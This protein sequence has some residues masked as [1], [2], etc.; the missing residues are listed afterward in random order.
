MGIR[1]FLRVVFC[2]AILCFGSSAAQAEPSP[3]SIDVL[4]DALRAKG[5]IDQQ[6]AD[7]VLAA[8]DEN[9]LREL[10]AALQEQGV[11]DTESA[12]E[13]LDAD[14]AEREDRSALDRMHLWGDFRNRFKGVWFDEDP[15]GD[16]RNTRTRGQLRLR[17]RGS[18]EVNQYFD[19]QVGVTTVNNNNPG[20]RKNVDWGKPADGAPDD[21]R[22]DQIFATIHP[23][24]DDPLPWGLGQ[25]EVVLGKF[26]P[27]F[28]SDVGKDQ[29]VWDPTLTLDGVALEWVYQPV[30]NVEIATQGSFFQFEVAQEPPNPRMFAMQVVPTWD[31]NDWLALSVS[32][33][34]YAY[35]KVENERDEF[36]RDGSDFGNIPEGLTDDDSITI[37]DVR[38]TATVTAIEKWPVVVYGRYLHNFSAESNSNFNAGKEDDA[39]SVGMSIGD[40]H[41]WFEI[42]GGFMRLEANAVPAQ[43]PSFEPFDGHTNL[44]VWSVYLSRSVFKNMLL[45][46]EWYR[47]RARDRN[48]TFKNAVTDTDSTRVNAGITMLF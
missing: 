44:D 30:S 14:T 1:H 16:E 6:T 45:E 31:V 3:D 33:T 19:M 10:V 2:A 48:I 35:Q 42:G 36:R 41:E 26:N 37:T 8:G 39:F 7:K 34:I 21:V 28:R 23:L 46:F 24:G 43:F 4:V 47:R 22:F 38:A 12:T 32:P 27:P 5:V 40:P 9:A 11:L 25:V 15:L 20:R 29:L 13:V 17:L 18:A